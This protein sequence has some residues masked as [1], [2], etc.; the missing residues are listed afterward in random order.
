MAALNGVAGSV[1]YFNGTDNVVEEIREWSLDLSATPIEVTALGDE[2]ERYI[3][4]LARATGS[5]I[6]SLDASG[7]AQSGL[8]SDFR[9]GQKIR[10]VLFLDAS[11]YIDTL[12]AYIT[13]YTPAIA[14]DGSPSTEWEFQVSGRIDTSMGAWV[15]LLESGD[16]LLAEDGSGLRGDVVNQW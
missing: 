4:N 11:T 2:E 6:G 14:I 5:F 16:L 10:L 13:G 8:R 7:A 1:I 9:D 15:L 3:P 12:D